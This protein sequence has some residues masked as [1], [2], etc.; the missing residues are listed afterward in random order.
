MAAYASSYI[1]RRMNQ[2]VFQ[3]LPC[4]VVHRVLVCPS[5]W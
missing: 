1:I 3:C 5:K 4:I 2:T